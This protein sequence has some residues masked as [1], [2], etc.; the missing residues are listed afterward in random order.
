[1]D[2]LVQYIWWCNCM[3]KVNANFGSSVLI[4]YKRK[5][6]FEWNVSMPR[7]KL[8]FQ[9]KKKLFQLSASA[10]NNCIITYMYVY[11]NISAI[12][13]HN[14]IAFLCLFSISN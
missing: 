2:G 4:L 6:D 10:C 12:E 13:T 5:A 9:E 7:E 8:N 11:Q 14:V 3:K 1:M